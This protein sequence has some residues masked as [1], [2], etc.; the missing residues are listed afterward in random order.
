MNKPKY[1]RIHYNLWFRFKLMINI[2]VKIKMQT[3]RKAQ[4][5][6][7]TLKT[8]RKSE[9]SKCTLKS[10]RIAEGSKSTL[11]SR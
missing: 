6:K 9:G 7:R 1:L 8:N 2:Y 4:G 10:R 5:S 11:K 3:S